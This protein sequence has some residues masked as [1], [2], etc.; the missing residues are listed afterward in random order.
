MNIELRKSFEKDLNN[1]RDEALLKKIKAVIE[2]VENAENLANISNIKKLQAD[3]NY[4]RIRIGDYRVGIIVSES[5]VIFV[6]VLHRKDVYRY[7]P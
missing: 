5:V 6:R 7:F 1:I 3:G 4:Y 2:D